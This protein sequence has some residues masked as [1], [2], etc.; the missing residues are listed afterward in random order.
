[1]QKF[2]GQRSGVLY[3]VFDILWIDEHNLMKLSLLDRK[4][5][6]KAVVDENPVIRYSD[7]FD[8]GEIL[9]DQIRSHHMEGIIAKLKDSP[10]IQGDRSSKWLK[11]PTEHRQEYVIGGWVE[12]EKDRHFRSLL[13][14]EFHDGELKW[15]GHA[16][17]GYR[18]KEMPKILDKLKQLEITESPFHNEV[19]YE[20]K[21]HWV[22]PELVA[23]IKFST[24]TKS[25]KI[26]K[27][28]IF[29]GFRNDKRAEQ[30]VEQKA[31]SAPSR[32]KTVQK[33][34]RKRELLTNADNK[35]NWPKID[36]IPHRNVESV[37]ID[38]CAIELYNV[39]NQLWKG[40]TKGDLIQYY[41]SISKFILPHIKERAL[42]L[43]LKHQGPN[44]PGLYI[45]D[46]EGRQPK[47]ADIFT[48]Q[49]KHKMQGK[50]DIIDYLVCN[51]TA[52]LLYAINLGCIDINPWTSTIHNSLYPDFIIID[53]DPSN[54]DFKKGV[55]VA[56]AAKQLFDKFELTSFIK[57][58]GKTG[59]HIFLPCTAFTFPQ[60]RFIAERICSFIHELVPD[61]STSETIVA[62]RDD[63]VYLDP[64]QNDYADTVASAY[65]VRPYKH[66]FISTPLEWSEMTLSLDPSQFTM[67]SIMNRLHKKRDLF[68]GTLDRE[69]A[70][71]ND[72]ILNSFLKC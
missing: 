47:C 43:H 41:I 44:A 67:K 37:D 59:L 55:E 53:I 24:F 19:E 14:G 49:R 22:K 25:G 68:S 71:K 48:T 36:A 30:V 11:I 7:D 65:S 63:K 17:G 34:N 21:P 31:I 35:S 40:I 28:A 69:I 10:Y 72:K 64:N 70:V 56:L 26:R 45:K 27:P 61:I 33:L 16:G 2:N 39:D 46:M 51:N 32:A 3:Y 9:F 57:T 50:R 5:I 15:I 38:G 20:G 23:N 1:L 8:D 12:S 60:A 18:E 6:L 54:D 29:L 66:P 13:F 58:S 62:N 4:K 42:S 52:T